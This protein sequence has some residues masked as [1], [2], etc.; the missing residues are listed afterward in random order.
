MNSM[1]I[2]TRFSPG[3]NKTTSGPKL[4]HKFIHS[5]KPFLLNFV[6]IPGFFKVSQISGLPGFKVFFDS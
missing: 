1:K 6:Q 3:K 4:N 5:S 2:Y